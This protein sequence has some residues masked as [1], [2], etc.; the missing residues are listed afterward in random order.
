[1]INP[2]RIQPPLWT[3]ASTQVGH[4]S[5]RRAGKELGAS[6]SSGKPPTSAQPVSQNEAQAAL[7]VALHGRPGHSFDETSL[8]QFESCVHARPNMRHTTPSGA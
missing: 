8:F 5:H 6:L 4:V 7:A 1:M 2:Q 3:R